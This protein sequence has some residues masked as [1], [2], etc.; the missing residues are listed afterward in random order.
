MACKVFI[1]ED[2]PVILGYLENVVESSEMLECVST[3]NTVQKALALIPNTDFDIALIDLG[4]PDGDG[5]QLIEYISLAFPARMKLILSSF[6]DE[7]KVINAIAKGANGYLLKDSSGM[8]ICQSIIDVING[9]AP[10][11]PNIARHLLSRMQAKPKQPHN[12]T[13]KELQ[14]LKYVSKGFRYREVADLLEVKFST[15][16]S[17]A[18]NIYKKLGVQSKN[19]AVYEAHQQGIIDMGDTH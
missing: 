13:E 7:I 3:A 19:E 10:M 15:V 18:K 5:T 8:D 9:G 1:I 2:D 4:L 16:A 11:S 14:V 6:S 17:H 12:L